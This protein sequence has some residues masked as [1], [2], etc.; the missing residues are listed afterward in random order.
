[1][2]L[3][4]GVTGVSTAVLIFIDMFGLKHKLQTFS[5]VSLLNAME[6][7]LCRLPGE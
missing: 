2:A 3:F 4:Q 5:F 7:K 1:M 6:R